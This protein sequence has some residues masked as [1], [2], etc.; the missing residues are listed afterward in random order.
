[1]G[2][3]ATS[4][5]WTE[6][7]PGESYG[8]FDVGGFFGGAFAGY[9]HQTGGLVLGIEASASYADLGFSDPFN[10]DMPAAD[11]DFVATAT[12][13]LGLAAG[14]WLFYATGGYA[15]AAAS[16]SLSDVSAPNTGRWSATGW[17]H[18]YTLGGG[19]DVR[20]DDVIVGV[21]YAYFDLGPVDMS[22]LDSNSAPHT[23]N[24]AARFHAVMGRLGTR[25]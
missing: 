1:L 12:G 4:G 9:N 7:G 18:G 17:L 10:D 20:L 2:V 24:V 3:T 25:F 22:A 11:I 21:E 8:A 23:F 6:Y 19:I 16:V 14:N 5:G 13:R 15:G